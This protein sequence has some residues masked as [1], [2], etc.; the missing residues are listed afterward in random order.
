MSALFEPGC[1]EENRQTGGSGHHSAF[2]LHSSRNG[3]QGFAHAKQ[4]LYQ[5]SCI[6]AH[7]ASP[8]E[9]AL[10]ARFLNREG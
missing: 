1:E 8:A 4:A 3:A 10:I 2:H 7:G 6:P 5:L 9:E